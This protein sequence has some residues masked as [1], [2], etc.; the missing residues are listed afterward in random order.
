MLSDMR[1]ALLTLAA[2]TLYGAS[3][4]VQTEVFRAGEG[5]YHT[6]R[7]PALITSPKG[8]LLAFCEGRKAGRRDSGDIDML[9]KRSLDNGKTWQATQIVWDDADNTCGNPC[10]VIDAKTGTI[11]LLMTHNLGDDGE[12]KIVSGTSKRSRTVW[13]TNSTD[14]GATWT[15]PVEITRDTKK[16][17]WTWYATGPGIGIQL[18][19][20]RLLV[21]CD[22]KV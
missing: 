22:N 10:P 18:R 7:I 21:P 4:P 19:S 16:P 11:W 14:D 15:K 8:T 20:G 17:D 1:L 6:Y 3:A 9:L 12:E 2:S 13:V 5:G